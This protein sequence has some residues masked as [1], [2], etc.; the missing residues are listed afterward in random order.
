MMKRYCKY[1]LGSLPLLFI[2]CHENVMMDAVNSD[3]AIELRAEVSQQYIT[4]ASDGGFVDGDEIGVYIVNYENGQPQTLQP[5][6]NHADNVRFTY[7]ES[8][9]KWTGS[10]QLYWKDKQTPIDAYG[11]YPFDAEMNSTQAYP[12]SVQKN[13]REQMKT[14]RQL[15]GYEQSDFLWAK[16]ENVVPSSAMITLQHHHIMAGIKV[17]LQEGA[18]FADG[19]WDDI[20]KSVLIENTILNSTIN[21][22]TG[23]VSVLNSSSAESVIPQQNGD[24]YR[25]VV[26]PQTVSADKSLLAIT[27]DNKTYR[28]TRNEAMVY[29]PGK[30]HQFTYEVHKS[31]ETGDYEFS[32]LTESITP[33]E[34]DP[35]SH[36]GEAREYVIV[37]VNEGQFLGDAIA[38]AGLDPSKIIN[39]KITGYLGSYK[40]R[41]WGEEDK[42]HDVRGDVHFDYIREKMPNL[43]AINLRDVVKFNGSVSGRYYYE[44]GGCFVNGPSYSRKQIIETAQG[45]EDPYPNPDEQPIENYDD[46]LPEAAFY[47]MKSLRYVVM[48]E[49]LKAIGNNAF[50]CTS[51]IGSIQLP[52]DLEYLGGGAF[53]LDAFN[54]NTGAVSGE[55]H[56]PNSLVY[57]GGGAFSGCFLTGELVLPERMVY[58]GVRAFGNSPFMTGSIHVPD[59]LKELNGEAWP[60]QIG[61]PCVIPQGIKTINRIPQGAISLYIPEGV[62]EINAVGGYAVTS[63]LQGD[64]HLPSTVK[65]IAGHA[66]EG[67]SMSHINIPEGIEIIEECTFY[68]C[69]NLLDTIVI[70]STVT[71]IRDKAFTHCNQLTAVVLPA[72]LLG[73][74]NDAFA[75]CF[76]LDYIECLGVNPPE[77]EENTF[78]GVEKDNFTVVVPEGAVETYKKAPYW[79]EFKR[80]SSDK[81]F[82]C[83]PMRAKLLNKSN[84]RDVVLNADTNWEVADCPSWIHVSPSSGYKKTELKITIDAMP[85]GSE[86]RTGAVT[87]QLSRN[88]ENGHPVT[89]TY[90]VQQF[91]YEYDEDAV[92]SM[93]RA[94]MGQ[95]GGIDILFLGDGYDAEDIANGSYFTD[96]LEE[97]KYFFGVEPYKTYKGYFNVSAAV[98]MS[99]ES[100]VLDSP[101]KWRN[102]KFSITYG[103][104][105]NGRLSV[106]FDDI[107]SYVLTGVTDCPITDDNVGRSLIIC[108]PNSNAYEG[109]TALYGDGSAIAVCPM[110]K[111][112][113]PNDARGLIQHEACGHGWAKLD[114]EYVYHSAY[115]Q[116]CTCICCSHVEGVEGMHAMGWGRN[117]SLT[118]KYGSVEWKHLLGH[119]NY[120]DI[121]DIYEGGHMHAKGIY[122]SEVN[123][124][125]N[126]NVPYFSTWSRQLAVERIKWAAGETFTFED[127][128]AND[129]REYGDKFLTRGMADVP[130]QQVNAT[131]SPNH[132]PIIKS[133]SITDYL[134]KKGGKR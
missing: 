78:S 114:D 99:Y 88:D 64:V 123:S 2:A 34:N 116:N 38:A 103:A 71:Q 60:N 117:V 48:P 35:E 106:P 4:R 57:I 26:I 30:L 96:M 124:C 85:H 79:N 63:H 97:M 109:L 50:A 28:P 72:G 66:F 91:D 118:G 70:P 102:T 122:R 51:L 47:Y 77:I 61:G 112:G 73:I 12:F 29:Y 21:V 58:L 126:N 17:V 32:L 40:E 9:G 20:Q 33:W 3:N 133:G 98:A 74:K 119:P 86:D 75:G 131:H 67:S 92:I 105:D 107:A 68:G 104:G 125:M 42:F 19:E 22:Q 95:R 53:A 82:V 6:G 43:E 108:V 113:Y 36:N 132:G 128:V 69:E 101:D 11:Y 84:V 129:S 15:S 121:V 44:E 56:L 89:C 54:S 23:M 5:T 111:L 100:G 45:K 27:V 65:K 59:G 49:R 14:G 39:L 24:T 1:I 31:M 115:I 93:Q 130:W 110:S 13:Q 94:T 62:E 83:R 8:T 87:F 7:S 46:C 16:K 18:G 10:Y 52:S 80:I 127:F 134:K 76:S 37:H 25:A 55:I 81:K 120:S 90:T 41:D